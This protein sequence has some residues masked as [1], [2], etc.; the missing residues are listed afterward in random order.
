MRTRNPGSFLFVV[1]F[2]AF[3]SV[4]FFLGKKPQA[5]AA[6]D[7]AFDKKA[8]VQVMTVSLSEFADSAQYPARVRSRINAWVT[9]ESA[10]HV[11]KILKPVGSKVHRGEVVMVIKNLD[12]VF[13]YAPVKITSPA[14]GFVTTLEVDLLSRVDR[15]DRLFSVTDPGALVVDTEIPSADLHNFKIGD[16]GVLKDQAGNTYDVRIQALSPA[17]DLKTGTANAVLALQKATSP[18]KATSQADPKP[19]NQGQ[20]GQVQFR[21]NPRKSFVLPE[22]SLILKSGVTYVRVLNNNKARLV[23]V[24]VTLNLGD[25]VEIGAVSGSVS[26][27]R[28]GDQVI[29]RW[30]RYISE[31]EEV[32][33]QAP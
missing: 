17:V 28:E 3:L 31:N 20:L 10:G 1:L 7:K 9:A 19:L 32:E 22:N 30:N 5:N 6:I 16:L 21:I 15:G 11:Q 25:K 23:P 33:V 13:N 24:K 2:A 18:K 12:P 27:L 14:D 26:G 8:L 4:V 29:T